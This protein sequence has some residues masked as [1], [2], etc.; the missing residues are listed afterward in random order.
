MFLEHL[1]SLLTVKDALKINEH[2]ERLSNGVQSLQHLI[3][4]AVW[5]IADDVVTLRYVYLEEILARSDLPVDY[6]ERVV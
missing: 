1:K 6:T 4:Q 3:L 5:R 2:S